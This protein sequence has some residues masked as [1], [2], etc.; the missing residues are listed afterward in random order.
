[1]QF[2]DLR[3][4]DSISLAVDDACY[5]TDFTVL[6]YLDSATLLADAN[7]EQYLLNHATLKLT[8]QNSEQPMNATAPPPIAFTTLAG[9]PNQAPVACVKGMIKKLHKMYSGTGDYGPFYNLPGVLMD[10]FQTEHEFK[11]LFWESP[12][13]FMVGQWAQFWCKS[14]GKKMGGVELVIEQY[15]GKAGPNKDKL[16][17]KRL[18]QVSKEANWAILDPSGNAIPQGTPP[19]ATQTAPVASQAPRQGGDS[20]NASR[21][22]S[23]SVNGQRITVDDRLDDIFA[24]LE[25][26]Y[27][28]SKALKEAGKIPELTGSDLKEITTTV[29]ISCEKNGFIRPNFGGS[30]MPAEQKAVGMNWKDV[31]HPSRK[32]ALGTLPDA[33]LRDSAIWAFGEDEV[34]EEYKPFKL[35]LTAMCL[36]NH[37]TPQSLL[38][39]KLTDLGM[40]KKFGP[41]DFEFIMERDLGTKCP[42]AEG[43]R[44]MCKKM[45][46]EKRDKLVVDELVKL[47]EARKSQSAVGGDLDEDDLD[48]PA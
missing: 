14:D 30:N 1:M 21:A 2:G 37:W 45:G 47:A 20:G 36:E 17:T 31:I 5:T 3:A 27:T 32:A 46:T 48:L 15:T 43:Y 22:P 23:G 19:N 6:K 7:G 34:K 13:P 42:D 28:R 18:I 44:Q 4:G 10:E 38:S 39:K 9:Y 29:L 25:K 33:I 24:I 40:G 35:A 12:P 8:K 26:A 16:V 41:D 11:C